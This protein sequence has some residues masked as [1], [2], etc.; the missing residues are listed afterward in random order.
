MNPARTARA[1]A[2]A[3]VLVVIVAGSGCTGARESDTPTTSGAVAPAWPAGRE[4]ELIDAAARGDAWLLSQGTNLPAYVPL[5]LDLLRRRFGLDVPA[6]VAGLVSESAAA[7]ESAPAM[8]VFSRLV[9]PS[10]SISSS[11]LAAVTDEIDRITAPA[12][13]CDQVGLPD[14]YLDLL[15]RAV[16]LGGYERTHAV[17][18]LQWLRENRCIDEAEA[19]GRSQRW[20]DDLVRT[21]EDER[22]GG[23]AAG[24]LAIEAMAMLAYTGHADRI[25]QAWIDAVLAAQHPDGSWPQGGSRPDPAP[26]ATVLAVWLLSELGNPDAPSIPWIPSG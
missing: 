13:A 1:A 8:R 16:A 5:L 24:D 20:A 26:H 9:D 3:L 15:E 22:A 23:D 25:E 11:D 18:A 19:A 4:A 6:A 21:V 10:V 12:L 2:A 14:G 7:G 17:L